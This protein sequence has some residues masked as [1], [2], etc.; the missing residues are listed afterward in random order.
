MLGTL[1]SIWLNDLFNQWCGEASIIPKPLR[2]GGRLEVCLKRWTLFVCVQL[3]AAVYAAFLTEQIIRQDLE[4][5]VPDKQLPE[6]KL[7]DFAVFF[8]QNLFQPYVE[9]YIM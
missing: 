1:S 8:W 2:E 5:I 3:H 7:E 6:L 9:V 4:P